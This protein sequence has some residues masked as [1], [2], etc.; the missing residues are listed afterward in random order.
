MTGAAAEIREARRDDAPALAILSTE[1][2]Y[3]VDAQRIA[4]RL[5]GLLAGRGDVV[6]VAVADHAGIVGFGHAAEKRLL[7]SEPFVELEGLIVTTAARRRGAAAG[8]VAAVER[9]TLERGVTELRVRARLER[10]VADLF[11]RR[12]GFALEKLQ[13]VLAKRLRV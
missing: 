1:L 7:V 12:Q 5:D 3:A 10:D 6:F 4:R 11:Y 2:G 13:R 8:L 9:W